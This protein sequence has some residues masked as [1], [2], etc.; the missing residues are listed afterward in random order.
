MSDKIFFSLAA[1][2]AVLMIALAAVWPQGL[3]RRSPAPFGH[4]SA[5]E[6]A[7]KARKAG[8]AKPARPEA[9]NLKPMITP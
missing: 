2:L 6:A 1:V 3:G 5:S 4:I 8:T 7:E 9:T